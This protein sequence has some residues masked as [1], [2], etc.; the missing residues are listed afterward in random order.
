MEGAGTPS[1]LIFLDVILNEAAPPF[2]IFGGWESLTSILRFVGAD[3]IGS[4]FPPLQ[5]AQ[6]W[7]SLKRKPG[8]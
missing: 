8:F 3:W 5:K 2:V 4:R 6:G 1:L 7:G